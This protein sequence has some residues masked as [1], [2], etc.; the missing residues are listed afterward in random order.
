M[1]AAERARIAAALWG[2][3]LLL[4][5]S[6]PNPPAIRAGGLPVDKA[7]HFVLYGVEAFLLHRAI[8]WRGRSG[9]AWSRVLAVVGT[10]ALWG[11]LDEAHQEWIPGRRMDSA[12]LAAD[13]AGAA[14]G[15]VMA[16]VKA[17]RS[18]PSV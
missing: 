7:T 14:V 12:D 18:E 10:M 5:T 2:G 16:G 3:F 11:A 13:I 15:S 6:W 4:S 1:T 9:F 17:R 8:G